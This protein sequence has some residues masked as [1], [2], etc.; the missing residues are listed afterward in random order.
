[1]LASNLTALETEPMSEHMTRA[2][3]SAVRRIL[4]TIVTRYGIEP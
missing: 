1:M 2:T 4:H 3:R